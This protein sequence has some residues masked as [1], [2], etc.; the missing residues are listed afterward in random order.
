[1]QYDF[2]LKLWAEFIPP[3]RN[4]LKRY[5][6][7]IGFPDIRRIKVGH[8]IQL[9]G[10]DDIVYVRVTSVQSFE[11]FVDV[12]A[13]LDHDSIAPGWGTEAIVRTWCTTYTL[14]QE[15]R[16]IFAFGIEPI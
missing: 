2:R 16:G 8:I 6:L 15:E 10:S 3:I 14:Q 9:Y 1:M 7:R 4:R 5:D 12:L 11:T 13:H